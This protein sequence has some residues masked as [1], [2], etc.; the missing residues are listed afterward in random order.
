MTTYVIREAGVGARTETGRGDILV[1]VMRC[2]GPKPI[3]RIRAVLNSLTHSLPLARPSRASCFAQMELPLLPSVS[4][5]EIVAFATS[6]PFATSQAAQ[7]DG[8]TNLSI[9][10]KSLGKFDQVCLFMRVNRQVV[11]IRDAESG[12]A[13]DSVPPSLAITRQ[14]GVT[15]VRSKGSSQDLQPDLFVS[16]RLRQA[17]SNRRA[18]ETERWRQC[19]QREFRAAQQCTV[20][21]HR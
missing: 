12:S 18:K 5:V 17:G 7:V 3:H 10:A 21:T 16:V 13:F 14:V 8:Y 1:T 2:S 20:S 6:K 15:R 11:R 4:Q 9:G 19:R